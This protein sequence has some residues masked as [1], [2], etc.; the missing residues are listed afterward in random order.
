MLLGSLCDVAQFALLMRGVTPEF[1][2]VEE[3]LRLKPMKGRT[4][5]VHT[6]DIFNAVKK[7][8]EEFDFSLENMFGI[9][10]DDAPWLV[11]ETV[12][13]RC[14]TNIAKKMEAEEISLKYIA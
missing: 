12:L 8:L 4:T 10:T 1:H 11:K 14:L 5:Y 6:V 2:I 9:T 3:F 7:V 13:Q